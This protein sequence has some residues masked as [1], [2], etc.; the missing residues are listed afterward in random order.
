LW[1]TLRGANATKGPLAYRASLPNETIS[2]TKGD[3]PVKPPKTQKECLLPVAL[4]SLLLLASCGDDYTLED[5]ARDSLTR[6]HT[7]LNYFKDAD[8]RY[9]FVHGANVSGSSKFPASFEPISYVGKPFPLEQ[10]DWNLQTLRSQGFNVIRLVMTWEAI[11]H[12]GP[13]VY[14][15]EYLDYIQKIVAKANEH[16]IY[17]LMDMHQDLF[18]RHLFQMYNDETDVS[19]LVEPGN[20]RKAEGCVLGRDAQGEPIHPNNLVRGDGAPEWAVALCLP[21]KDVGG[22]VWG[23]PRSCARGAASTPAF[24]PYS[25]WGI[26]IFLSIDVSRCFA[27]FFAGRDVYPNYTVPGDGRNIQDYLQ[28]HFTDAWRQVARR[29]AGYPNVLGYDILNEPSG[30][31]ILFSLYTI[32]WR[33]TQQVAGGVLSE[34]QFQAVLDGYLQDLRLQ[35]ATQDGVNRLREVLL[36]NHV[37]P[38]SSR[39]IVESG[40][41]PAAAASPYR[42]DPEAGVGLGVHFNRDH[43][44]PFHEKVGHAILE[45]DPDAIIFIELSLGSNET[46]VGGMMATPMRRPAGIDQIAYAPHW[47]TDI[48]PDF[49]ENQPP[50]DFTVEEKF[51]R[52]Y[53]PQIEKAIEPST[54]SLGKP[55]TVMGEFGTYF[56]FGGIE[57]SMAQDYEVSSVILDRYF[58]TYERILLHHIQWCYSSE[59]TAENGEGWNKE[60]FSLLGPD[61]RPRSA[62]AYS[63]PYPRYLSGKPVSMHFYSDF[64]YYDPDPYIPDPVREFEVVFKTKETESPTE[65]FV[66]PVQY[67]DGFY[68]YISDGYCSYDARRF[69]LYFYPVRRD[70]YT[71]HSLRLR[72]PYPDYGDRDWRYF[73]QGDRMIVNEP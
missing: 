36:E 5:Q 67:P 29:V 49:G 48:Y 21:D 25:L 33:G 6:I 68:V 43:L 32:F 60:D 59:N 40:F 2:E 1:G 52:D 30:F 37:L 46:G 35:G 64:H 24:F 18:S 16:G 10:A 73:F 3:L 23:L 70:P 20:I 71:L 42:P 28:D 39:E 4:A 45:E 41:V 44:Q 26:N 61:H 12:A 14:D 38:H 11:E 62:L 56:N 72:P 66:P 63:R 54:F 19:S 58:E 22:D 55:P 31:Y 65:I 50:R 27:T 47:Y 9:M 8:G 13:G 53:T 57:T 17:C 34:T 69:I 15:T 7:E 51:F